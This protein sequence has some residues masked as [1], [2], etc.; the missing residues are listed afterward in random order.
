M[1][2]DASPPLKSLV[3]PPVFVPPLSPASQ[4]RVGA[5]FVVP[6][7]LAI[8]AIGYLGYTLLLAQQPSTS[9]SAV[10][11]STPVSTVSTASPKYLL[12][13]VFTYNPP[14]AG[15]G[16]LGSKGGLEQQVGSMVGVIGE[17]GD[18]ESTQL[19]FVVGPLVFDMTDVELRRAIND[20]F[21][22]AIEKDVA[23]GFHIDDSMFW[24][25]RK[26]LWSDKSNVEWSDWQ[27]TTVKHRIIGWAA[28][29]GPYLAPPMCYNSPAI[30]AEATRIGRDVIGAEIKKGI[31]HLNSLGKGYLFAGVIAGW[32]TRMQDDSNP[33]VFYGYCALHNLGYSAAKPPTDTDL[34]L[35]GVVSDWIVLW[36]KALI[37]AG[38]SQDKV[39]TH[40][41]FPGKAPAIPAARILRDWY[42][43]SDP[44]ITAFNDLSHPSFSVYGTENFPALHTLLA[45]QP[46]EPWGIAEGSIEGLTTN[47]FGVG[48]S[49]GARP[50][51]TSVSA[52]KAENYLAGVFNHNG[53]YVNLFGWVAGHSNITTD[54]ISIEG[55]KKFLSGERLQE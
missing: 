4:A 11:T 29:G 15:P 55:Y 9:G 18:H 20:A 46:V 19:G 5:W 22:V 12:F 1:P 50:G 32:E 7:V 17:R 36:G 14:S 52:N 47:A 33:P 8:S 45:T 24:I 3:P 6:G 44:A 28:G 23:V 48:G 16:A 13:Q 31:D 42:K 38:I 30:K 51:G 2:P 25:N 10:A 40:I 39:F 49:S 37:D 26:D 27:G 53:V 21:A 43:G 41:A 54:P 34:A 35:Q